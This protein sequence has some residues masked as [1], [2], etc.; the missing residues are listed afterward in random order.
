MSFIKN[1]KSI[2]PENDIHGYHYLPDNKSQ[3]VRIGAIIYEQ[4][5]LLLIPSSASFWQVL[6]YYLPKTDSAILVNGEFTHPTRVTLDF[7]IDNLESFENNNNKIEL[8]GIQMARIPEVG[9]DIA[10]QDV[11]GKMFHKFNCRQIVI[12][13]EGINHK[14]YLQ[15]DG[16]YNN[17][18][19]IINRYG[20]GSPLAPFS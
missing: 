18:S 1:V 14:I 20:I 13:Q 15:H 11:S 2:R 8:Y 4:T 9:N 16:R 5:E 3:L 19:F 7:E 17:I 10:I 6:R 12:N